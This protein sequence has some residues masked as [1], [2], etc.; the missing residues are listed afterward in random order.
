MSHSRFPP[1]LLQY[2]E[3]VFAVLLRSPSVA[4]GRN[5][6]EFASRYQ[7]AVAPFHS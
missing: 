2:G 7:N 1:R 5:L 4:A 6:E 3:K